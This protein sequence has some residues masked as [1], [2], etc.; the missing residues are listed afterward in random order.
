MTRACFIN[1]FSRYTNAPSNLHDHCHYY[2]I[3]T[4]IATLIHLRYRPIASKAPFCTHNSRPP[5]S[6]DRNN[7]SSTSTSLHVN[8]TRRSSTVHNSRHSINALL[9]VAAIEYCDT[10]RSHVYH[11]KSPDPVPPT[12]PA[13]C[14]RIRSSSPAAS[15]LVVYSTTYHLNLP[16]PPSPPSAYSSDLKRSPSMARKIG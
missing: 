5:V 1:S 8:A 6:S 4:W 10:S 16:R 2:L 14:P 12:T 3:I 13:S 7:K 15:P 11:P 9:H